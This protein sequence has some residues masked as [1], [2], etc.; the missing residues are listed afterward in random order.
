MGKQLGERQENI[1][2]GYL[3]KCVCVCVTEGKEW[4]RA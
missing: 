1:E 2:K 4:P 3:S